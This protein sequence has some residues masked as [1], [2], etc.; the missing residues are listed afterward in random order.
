MAAPA[1][2]QDPAALQ[3]LRGQY[4]AMMANLGRVAAAR[5]D[6][7]TEAQAREGR[8]AMKSLTDQQL[9][10]I[11]SRTR[12]PDLSV[13]ATASR[14]LVR[15]TDALAKKDA[16]GDFVQLLAAGFPDPVAI[17]A[18]CNGVDI[19]ADT[20]YALLITKE[21]TSSILAA[22]AFVCNTSILGVNTSL[23]CVPF[24]IAAS[25]AIGLFDTATFC[26][27]EVTANQIDANFNRLDH[28]HNDLTSGITTVVNNSNANTAT[29]IS[30]ANTNTTT[31]VTNDNTNAAT[32]VANDNSN[33]AAILNNATANKNELRDLVLRTQI[34][35]DL[36]MADS[37]AVVAL[38][39]LPN[40]HGGYLDLVMAIV[41]ETIADI[42]AAGGRVSNAQSA[43]TEANTAKAAGDFKTA[44]RLYRKAYK[45]AGR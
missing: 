37:A 41:T 17:P 43:L 4:D 25:I 3:T 9:A 13:A 10:E 40:T 39:L 28:I 34:E 32:I 18:G 31:I 12:V 22:A 29:I 45:A 35:A 6:T 42:R 2:A 15:Q 1:F 8:D 26:A 5:G 38:Y 11:Y 20:R 33:T 21:V 14:F 16:G 19:S 24:S 7:V 27:G 44:Y 23:A 36:S 30:N